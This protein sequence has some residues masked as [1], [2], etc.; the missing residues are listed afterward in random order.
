MA[1]VD[2]AWLLRAWE[3][4]GSVVPAARGA[5]LVQEA[6]LTADLDTALDLPVG[7]VAGLVARVYAE[8]FGPDADAVLDCPACGAALDVA[9]PVGLVA[10]ADDGV[11]PGAGDVTLPSGRRVQVRVPSTRDLLAVREDDDVA[12]ALLARCVGDAGGT[13]APTLDDAETAVV[14]AALEEL[15]GA[16]CVVVRSA[17]PECGTGVAGQVD[18]AA[19]LWDRIDREAPGVLADIADLAASFGWSEAEILALTPARRASYLA[20]VRGARA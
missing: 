20:L 5:V 14:D 18:V 13:E 2:P 10:S 11:G 8:Q 3:S 12:A 9:V 1:T 7:S 6:G 19:F 4:A 17:C 15:A 16:A